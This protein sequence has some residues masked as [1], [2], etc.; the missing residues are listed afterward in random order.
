MSRAFAPL[1]LGH[2]KDR[3]VP[4]RI[5]TS[6]A[7]EMGAQALR[8]LGGQSG[9]RGSLG[10]AVKTTEL[11]VL[12]L[13]D[14]FGRIL[15]ELSGKLLADPLAE[16]RFHEPAGI[17]ARLSGETPGCNC[18]FTL[19]ID[20]NFNGLQAAPPFTWMVSLIEPFASC[21]STT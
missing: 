5:C 2:E 12:P 20:K 9:C 13:L 15:V 10:K 14:L 4:G 16:G 21:C 7:R 11:P 3:V 8:T 1:S 17:A 18:R 6:A 19:G